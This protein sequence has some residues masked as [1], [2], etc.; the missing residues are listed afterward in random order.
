MAITGRFVLLALA[1]LIPVMLFPTGWT[2]LLWLALL[3]V[4]L[5]I[6]LALA[7]SAR[8][9]R[10]HRSLPENVRLTERTEAHLTLANGSARM[11]RAQVREAWQPSAGAVNPRQQILVPAGERGRITV[12]LLPTR[13]GDLHIGTTTIR[14]FGPLRMAA[15]Q[16]TVAAPGRLRVL[17]EFRSKRQL[18]AKLRKLRELDGRAAVQIRGAGTEFDSLRDYVRGDDVRSIDWRATA[19]RRDVVVRTWRPERDRRLVILLDTS[20]TSAARIKDEPSLDTG[21]EAAL[22]L[23][24]LA[25]RGGDRVDFLAFDRRVRAR[26][27]SASRGNLLGALV[28]AMAP[29]RSELIEMDWQ[30]IPGQVRSVSAHRSLLVLLTSLDSGAPEEGLI[31]MLGQLALRHL[32]VVASVRDPLLGRLRIKRATASDIYR[33]AAAERALLDRETLAG[34]LRRQ[35]VE[36]VD[37]EPHELPSKLA[38]LYIRLKAAGRL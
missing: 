26:V 9:V 35:G 31:P 20:R 2:I 3:A 1:G 18:P 7:A 30:Q 16:L 27:S 23:A 33:A 8:T 14:S 38:D 25:E 32:V 34:L 17:P 12:A 13:R 21:I 37:A 5:I 10:L 4:V 11:L 24:V 29:L 22:L 28:H 6:D 19:R 36:V 15:R